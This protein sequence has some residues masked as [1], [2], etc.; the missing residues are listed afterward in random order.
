MRKIIVTR[1]PAKINLAVLKLVEQLGDLTSLSALASDA[2]Y[3]RSQAVAAAAAAQADKTAAAAARAGAEA[4]QA[5]AASSSGT[6]GAHAS[7]SAVSAGTSAVSAS[8]ASG[9]AVTAAAEASAAQETFSALLRAFN[10]T[11][12]K[13]VSARAVYDAK[14]LTAQAG[15]LPENSTPVAA[16]LFGTDP[17][18]GPYVRRDLTSTNPFST[19][20]RPVFTM[21]PDSVFR[22]RVKAR[23]A[24]PTEANW[25]LVFLASDGAAQVRSIPMTGI[26]A[27]EVRDYEAIIGKTAGGIVTHVHPTAADWGRPYFRGGIASMELISGGTYDVFV[28]DIEDV[29]LVDLATRAAQAANDAVAVSVRFDVAQTLTTPQKTQAQANLGLGSVATEN[30]VP[31]TKG[32]TGANNATAARANFQVPWT[33]DGRIALWYVVSGSAAI[34]PSGGR[35]AYHLIPF[36]DNILTSGGACGSEAGGTQV[37]PAFP[38]RVYVGWYWRIA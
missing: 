21:T 25:R 13:L 26:V 28:L 34:L 27:G 16:N 8:A 18:Y 2:E 37:A 7:A 19:Y 4:A 14:M 36:L 3:A 23:F 15:N 17:T 38:G 9:S 20:T 29:T 33:P 11:P 35:Y 31:V 5:S 32:G 12:N 22:I 10:W 30:T 24:Q 1:D 6:A